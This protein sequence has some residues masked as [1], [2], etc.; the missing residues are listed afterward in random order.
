MEKRQRFVEEELEHQKEAGE[1]DGFDLKVKKLIQ[2][3][4]AP[5]EP[6]D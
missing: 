3:Q 4:R 2:E 1:E 5:K 6:S